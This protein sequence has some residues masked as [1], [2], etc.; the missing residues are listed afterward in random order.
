[1]VYTPNAITHCWPPHSDIGSSQ[2]SNTPSAPLGF[3]L[4]KNRHIAVSK[5][6]FSFDDKPSASAFH[7]LM[8]G[9]DGVQHLKPLF[10]YIGFGLVQSKLLANSN[11]LC[12][13]NKYKQNK[14]TAANP[15]KS[16]G[17]R[18]EVAKQVENGKLI[19]IRE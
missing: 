9:M 18:V 12:A 15:S 14:S 8:F 13:T 7:G 17:K 5:L 3:R 10:A 4:A 6:W 11:V 19:Y 16:R 1:M 2:T